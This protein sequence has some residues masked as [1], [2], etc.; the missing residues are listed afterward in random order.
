MSNKKEFSVKVYLN[1]NNQETNLLKDIDK[2]QY[3]L[4]IGKKD[5]N[6]PFKRLLEIKSEIV[7]QIQQEYP[8]NDIKVTLI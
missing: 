4:I 6:K 5:A 7:K 2:E 8:N 1:E 3:T